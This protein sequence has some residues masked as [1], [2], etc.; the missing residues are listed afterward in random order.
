MTRREWKTTA[1]TLAF[2]A[3]MALLPAMYFGVNGNFELLGQWIRQESGTQLGE[4]EIWFPNQ[5]LRG[6]LMRYLT[7]IDYSQVPDSNYP[8]V[9]IAAIDPAAVRLLWIAV[10]LGIYAAFLFLVHRR[11][12]GDGTL[13]LALAFCLIALLQPFTQKYALSVLLWPAIA[14]ARLPRKPQYGV[15]LHCAIV[16]ALV[17]PL[18]PG[19]GAQRLLQVLGLD[20]AVTVLLA[21]PIT[22]AALESRE[23]GE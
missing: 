15:L 19:A 3:V 21:G 2:A 11:R 17:Q 18:A 20:F 13:E 9:N 10:A 12:H 23:T 14:A 6:V 22:L 8:P 7:V 16:L 1:Y 5:S 4:S